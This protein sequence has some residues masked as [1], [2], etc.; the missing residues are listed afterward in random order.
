[1]KFQSGVKNPGVI[2]SYS[3]DK[4]HGINI[5]HRVWRNCNALRGCEEVVNAPC[6]SGQPNGQKQIASEDQ[7]EKEMKCTYPFL[8]FI[9]EVF[10]YMTLQWQFYWVA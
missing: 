10:M 3:L 1:M 4:L 6:L 9:V 7:I 2:D 5:S 8:I